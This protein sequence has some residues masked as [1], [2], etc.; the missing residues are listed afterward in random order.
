MRA[1]KCAQ[2]FGWRSQDSEG[3]D[4]FLPILFLRP[5]FSLEFLFL[6]LSAFQNTGD[7]SRTE[8]SVVYLTFVP[9]LVAV[10]FFSPAS[11]INGLLAKLVP[12]R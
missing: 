3:L 6:Y 11:R 1:Q 4:P 2:G 12:I 5:F 9:Q 10:V 7:P 8:A